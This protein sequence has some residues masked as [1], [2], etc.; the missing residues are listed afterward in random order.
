MMGSV[1]VVGTVLLAHCKTNDL[2]STTNNSNGLTITP[3]GG[4]YAGP[5]G[6]LLD[7]PANAVS[8]PVQVTI[9]TVAS[10][11]PALPAGSNLV[12]AVYS[13]EPYETQFT[14]PITIYLPYAPAT[15]SGVPSIIQ[16]ASESASW[17]A[18]ETGTAGPSEKVGGQSEGTSSAFTSSLGVFALVSGASAQD[19]GTPIDAGKLPDGGTSAGDGGIPATCPISM[20]MAS[21]CFAAS[22][23]VCTPLGAGCS[24]T[25]MTPCNGCSPTYTCNPGDAGTNGYGTCY[26]LGG[27]PSGTDAPED[28]TSICASTSAASTQ[29]LSLF[30]ATQDWCQ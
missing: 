12:G 7:V 17:G 1:A 14:V 29:I 10:G 5:D 3:S 20:A 24:C 21:S 27:M 26:D 2:S 23:L 11:Y 9:T 25:L 28:C 6:L 16:A 18:P 13:L 15:T 22:N 19:S 30:G 8:A 4:E